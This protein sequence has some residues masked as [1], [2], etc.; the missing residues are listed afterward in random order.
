[1][2]RLGVWLW[3][4]VLWPAT[5]AT[6]QS[7]P[8]GAAAPTTAQRWAHRAA[9]A[10]AAYRLA[11]RIKALPP[12]SDAKIGDLLAR[13]GRLGVGLEAAL[14]SVAAESGAT[15]GADGTCEV[16]LVVTREQIAGVLTAICRRDK[17]DADFATFKLPGDKPAL[18]MTA[19]AV[20]QPALRADT[21]IPRRSGEGYFDRAPA[22]VRKFW[23]DHV[24]EDGRARAEAAARADATARL[25]E[26]VRRLPLAPG[27]AM[28]DLVKGMGG[29]EP[30]IAA[31]LLAARETRLGHDTAA[32]VVTVE[33]E[34]TLR[35]VYA[36][37]KAWLHGRPGAKAADI[38]RFERLIVAARGATISRLGI[39]AAPRTA[40]RAPTAA[41]LAAIRRAEAV[42][43]W[44]GRRLTQR[45]SATVAG[46]RPF[47][48][49]Q[50]RSAARSAELQAR[51]ALA[52]R[53][54]ALK[55]DARTTVGDWA[56]GDRAARVALL[57]VLEAARPTAEPAF[58]DGTVTVDLELPLESLWRVVGAANVANRN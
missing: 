17:T 1:M 38:R 49:R 39:G 55:I 16:G 3:A 40:L 29:G 18:R 9:R 6:G 33:M 10:E 23:T 56:A 7:V 22:A 41:Q 11:E 43:A 13:S 52:G 20:A 5:A 51:L 21:M 27:V 2:N 53:V 30:E 24:T 45:G 31:L 54:E 12:G 28:A 19:R 4:A 15:H 48:F 32:A 14:L 26:Q 58:A 35:T 34:V 42:P 36:C 47:G 46:K 50:R 57:T 37:A 25:L 8:A 44:F